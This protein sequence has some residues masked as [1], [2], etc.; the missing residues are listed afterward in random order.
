[1]MEE[2]SKF[3]SICDNDDFGMDAAD[4]YAAMCMSVLED[5]ENNVDVVADFVEHCLVDEADSLEAMIPVVNGMAAVYARNF[6]R[7]G[8][9]GGVPSL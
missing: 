9:E 6:D 2:T 7:D 5:D 4:I 8:G 3:E 1:M